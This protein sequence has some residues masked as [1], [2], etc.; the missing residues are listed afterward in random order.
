MS[1]KS[2]EILVFV[3]ILGL[4]LQKPLYA[5]PLNSL[6]IENENL[7]IEKILETNDVI[8]GF[9]F[10][11]ENEEVIVFTKRDGELVYYNVK[12]KK[13]LPIKGVP[14]V[15][16]S[17]QG[18]LL[19]VLYDKKNKNLYLT[20]SCPIKKEIT[21]CLYRGK[22]DT[23]TGVLSGE[24][25]FEAKALSSNKIHYGSRLLLTDKDELFMTVGERNK[26]DLAQSLNV[27]NGKVL[28]LTLDG[29]AYA[30]NPFD[31]K[32]GLAEIYSYGHRN[33]QGIVQNLN[34]DILECEFGP[35]GGDEVNLI[36]PGLN[37]G[38]PKATYGSEYWGPKIGKNE[39][40]GMQAPVVY[41]VPSISPSGMMIYKS[42]TIKSIKGN[43]F[44]A[45]LAGSHVRRV[46]FDDKYKVIK[47]ESYLEALEDRFRQ[48][49]ESPKG[50]IYLS[51]DSGI[52]YK[53]SP[54]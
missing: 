25:I 36:K 33:P 43:A 47:Q 12:N 24:I 54:S 48:I 42:N 17:S 13:M 27:H 51:T 7:K 37:Y 15:N 2:K 16:N 29:K 21:T 45:N 39:L 3:F 6:K 4:F 35:R 40:S 1:K 44:L 52:I 20:L 22:L 30:G 49:K 31:G 8:W 32:N 41:W 19:D 23:K 5:N 46:V 53:I 18:G 26:R 34:G 9:D 10:L 50:Y 14:V 38:W 28:R 11:D